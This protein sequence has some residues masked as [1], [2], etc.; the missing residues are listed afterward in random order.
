M[1]KGT[2]TAISHD[3]Q[4]AIAAVPDHSG[5]PRPMDAEFFAPPPPM[6]GKIT[7]AETS[8]RQGKGPL[9]MPVRLTIAALVAGVII[10]GMIGLGHLS[11]VKRQDREILAIIGYII[12][13]IAAAIVMFVTRFKA[14]CGYVGEE[15]V[16]VFTMRRTRD[17][18]P[19]MEM[20]LFTD[21]AE[22]H[23]SQTR[24]FYNGV[25]TGTTY[26]YR[27]TDSAGRRVFRRNGTYRGKDKPPK[28][29]D[30]FHFADSAEIA[31]SQ[32][33]LERALK[34]LEAEGSMSFR[35]DRKRVVRV[36]PGF[37]EFHF[38]AEPV[39]VTR[40]DIAAV[41][42]SEGTFSFKH[43]DA[44]WYSL[45]GKY[46]FQYGMMANPKVFI[47]ALDKLMGYSWG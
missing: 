7:S 29:G 13:A 45:S 36:G 33:Y 31:W 23:A 17:A 25:Y 19:E 11:D 16:A 1:L 10:A 6:I 38:G 47:L 24:Q 42:L 5:Q 12:A 44:K 27:W 20:F 40:D 32:H 2:S 37:L 30:P 35:V 41:S 22:V 46:N 18:E 21:A 8:L 28:Q 43:K 4:Q 34:Q 14:T 39:R 26:D 15:G 3:V 9:S